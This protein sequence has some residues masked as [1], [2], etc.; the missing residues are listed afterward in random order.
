M[1]KGAAEARAVRLVGRQYPEVSGP[2]KVLTLVGLGLRCSSESLR[3]SELLLV[4]LRLRG[5]AVL[6][7]LIILRRRRFYS[8]MASPANAP[9]SDG[10][11]KASLLPIIWW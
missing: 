4:V 3:G 6:S 10:Q 1:K 9:G 7:I 11:H 2:L 8:A 5:A